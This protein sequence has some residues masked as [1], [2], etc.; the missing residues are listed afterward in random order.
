MIKEQGQ[1][2]KVREVRE[3]T[4]GRNIAT[5]D[6]MRCILGIIFVNCATDYCTIISPVNFYQI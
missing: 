2:E 1:Y 5:G 4:E 6:I 3:S